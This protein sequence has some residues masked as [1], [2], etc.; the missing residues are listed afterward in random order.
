MTE[1]ER[2]GRVDPPAP[3][4]LDA[5]R[6]VLWSAVAAE[7]LATAPPGGAQAGGAHPEAAGV[8]EA[9]RQPRGEDPAAP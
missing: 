4:V 3:G 1:L 5:A 9:A 8:A 6:E 7:M 2:L